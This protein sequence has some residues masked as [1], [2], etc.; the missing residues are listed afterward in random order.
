MKKLFAL[1]VVSVFLLR[2]MQVSAF[3]P[4]DGYVYNKYGRP[5]PSAIG[6]E[7]E[8]S[9]NSDASYKVFLNMPMDMVID[10]TNGDFYIADTDNNQIIIMD[11]NYQLIKILDKLKEKDGSEY[12]LNKPRGIYLR[13]QTLYIADTGNNTLVICDK[14]GNIQNK[15]TKPKSELFPAESEFKPLKV[16]VDSVG[17]VYVIVLGLFQGAACFDK[18][19]AFLEF[20]GANRVVGTAAL[21][22][23]L[24]WKNLLNR[25]Q[26]DQL[27]RYNPIE[28][29]GFD[30]DKD[31]FI[32]TCTSQAQ[33]SIGE[34][35][36]LNPVGDNVWDDSQNFGDQEISVIQNVTLDTTFTDVAVDE[37]GFV[38]GLDK[39]R[40]RV[41]Q[42]DNEGSPVFIFG[43]RGNTVGTFVQPSAIDV[44]DGKV[45]VLDSAAGSITRFGKTEYG[46]L[47]YEAILFFNKGLYDASEALWRD[48]IKYNANHYLGYIGIGKTLFHRGEYQEA[49]DY[50][51]KGNS[52]KLE[53]AA[54]E[55]Y[56]RQIVRD[57]FGWIVAFIVLLIIAV[58][59][60]VKRKSWMKFFR[61]DGRS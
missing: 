37:N 45:Y 12:I 22:R 35:R 30:I 17:N 29:S 52:K 31:D 3:I 9:V 46:E 41:F 32:Y 43:S 55:E 59:L 26:R 33:S 23:D 13:N 36:K 25:N 20:Y 6:Y 19:G 54:F 5:V 4:Y 53:S 51:E 2:S 18:D 16:V 14:E 28:Y 47:A 58:V 40:G 44:Y 8:K 57:Q 60:V 10:K 15:L 50:F 56:R 27:A 7:P 11:K 21:L 38:Y 39:E 61:K 42:Y 1:L 49:M 24:F 48:V 34:L